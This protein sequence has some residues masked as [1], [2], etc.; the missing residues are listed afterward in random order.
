MLV[1]SK[2]VASSTSVHVPQRAL[3]K[4]GVLNAFRRISSCDSMPSRPS[5][6]KQMVA[7]AWHGG[8]GDRQNMEFQVMRL[9]SYVVIC[10]FV[11]G[12]AV[13]AIAQDEDLAASPASS[14]YLPEVSGFGDDW[15]EV[16]RFGLE[17]P[18]DIFQEGSSAV[19]AGPNG[20]R[21]TVLVFL[22]TDDRVAIRQSWE[23]ASDTF[24]S[25]RY[26][27]ATNYDYSQLERL[28]AMPPPAGCV[29]SKR[30]E[31]T[32]NY[33]GFLAGVTMCA[34]DP[35]L[36]VIAATSGDVSGDAGYRASD[37]V[38]EMAIATVE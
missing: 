35:D 7:S 27:V 16:N 37:S 26:N 11:A 36:I 2:L 30:A 28:E 25:Y 22:V 24:D 1:I 5:V 23:E 14:S 19:Y 3:I 29:E 15:F 8:G 31:G 32:D 9:I 33:F 21:I 13:P 38:I 12:N 17:V 18:T 20:A 6:L 4:I 10:L 34:I